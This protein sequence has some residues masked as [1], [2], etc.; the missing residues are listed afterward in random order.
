VIRIRQG[1][2][3]G[4]SGTE[5]GVSEVVVDLD[6][7]TEKDTEKEIERDT[8]KNLIKA[9]VKAINYDFLTGP[10]QPGDK[11]ILNTTAQ[12]L[13]LGTGG[14][15]FVLANITNKAWDPPPEG[16]IMK[17]RYTPLQVKVLAVE[18]EHSPYRTAIEK[19]TSLNKAPVIVGSLH[20]QLP[21][22]A[23]GIKKTSGGQLRVGFVMTDGAALPLPYS[24]LVRELK[25]KG[26]IDV[27]VTAG[28]AFGG[29]LEA[30]NVYT[31]IIAAKEVGRADVIIVAMGPGIVGT[32]TEFGFSGVE[33]G[34]ILNAVNVVGGKA[35]CLPRI[36]FADPRERHTGV[37][38]HTLTVLEKIAVTPCTV[39]LP[40]LE[41]MKANFIRQQ[42]SRR[43]ITTRHQVEEL[44][45]QDVLKAMVQ[46]HNLKVTTMGR[47]VEEDIEF[48]LASCAAGKLAA[49]FVVY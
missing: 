6:E 2:V 24:H 40:V 44:D 47:S 20:S 32:G 7:D 35:S 10:V 46:Q 21:G 18:E 23:V 9:L 34:E 36:S 14:V 25:Q 4:I 26:L 11:V 5:S 12:S 37:S 1:R 3:T 30:V 19:F 38:H 49:G 43:G 27:T 17:L 28:H 42:L 39:A 29:D 8:R 45:A 22:A 16:H 31:G 48:F 41:N 15:H 33:Q 13:G